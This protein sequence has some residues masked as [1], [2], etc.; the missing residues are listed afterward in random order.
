ML[1]CNLASLFGTFG[2]FMEPIVEN[3]LSHFTTI[4]LTLV[5]IK[6]SVASTLP[7]VPHLTH[8][9]K[10]LLVCMVMLF[11]A[12]LEVTIIQE[13]DLEAEMVNIVDRS[14]A[15]IYIVILVMLQAWALLK[16]SGKVFSRQPAEWMV[17]MYA[18]APR[19]KFGVD[20]VDGAEPIESTREPSERSKCRCRRKGFLVLEGME[21][22]SLS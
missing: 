1:M 22:S 11:F 3:R 16:N 6:F 12:A 18:A 9:D 8:F 19:P 15:T 17:P 2:F 20:G 5:A 14:T 4:L 7:D 13:L 21:R 10:Y